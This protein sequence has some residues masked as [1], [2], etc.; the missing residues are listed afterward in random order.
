MWKV[1]G[2]LTA[3]Q[4]AAGIEVWEEED[5]VSLKGAGKVLVAFATRV[6]TPELLRQAAEAWLRAEEH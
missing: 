6:A 1:E 2:I 4:E 3:E 5:F